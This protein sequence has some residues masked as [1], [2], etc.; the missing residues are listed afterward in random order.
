MKIPENY[1]LSPY[2]E[3]VG[4]LNGLRQENG[5]LTASI[6]NIS[7]VFPHELEET[8]RHHVGRRIGI[9]RTDIPDKLYLIRTFPDQ[10]D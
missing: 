3:V 7:L 10:E 2:E 6:G 4:I 9:L 8:L 5:S 1:R